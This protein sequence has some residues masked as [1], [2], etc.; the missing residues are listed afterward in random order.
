[1][2]LIASIIA[3]Y[4]ALCLVW[5]M[6]MAGIFAGAAMQNNPMT[7][8]VIIYSGFIVALAIAVTHIWGQIKYWKTP[9]GE[10]TK[11]AFMLMY[12]S[13]PMS[14]VFLVSVALTFET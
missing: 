8:S 12:A 10:K 3:G 2:K 5:V 7:G 9:K 13:V 1:V 14:L 4:I 6:P 11:P